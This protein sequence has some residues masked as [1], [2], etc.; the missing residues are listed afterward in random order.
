MRRLT[1]HRLRAGPPAFEPAC[2]ACVWAAAT[3]RGA[4]GARHAALW[5]GSRGRRSR[6]GR[7]R[8]TAPCRVLR[9]AA[10][11]HVADDFTCVRACAHPRP[12]SAP[13]AR[14]ARGGTFTQHARAATRPRG[15]PGPNRRGARPEARPLGRARCAMAAGAARRARLAPRHN[16][17]ARLSERW[18]HVP[19]QP[20]ISERPTSPLN[21]WTRLTANPCCLRATGRPSDKMEGAHG[22]DEVDHTAA[23]HALTR[24]HNAEFKADLLQVRARAQQLRCTNPAALTWRHLVRGAPRC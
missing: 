22:V 6:C 12:R 2:G 11:G 15:P 9:A 8:L 21:W 5:T 16:A 3:P 4:V 14:T 24:K 18:A 10:S 19:A 23:Q 7:H 1:P 13:R 20:S 17:R